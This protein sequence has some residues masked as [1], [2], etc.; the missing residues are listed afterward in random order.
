MHSILRQHTFPIRQFLL[1]TTTIKRNRNINSRTITKIKM[2][3][4]SSNSAPKKLIT[5]NNDDNVCD[6]LIIGG[7]ASGWSFTDTL[8]GTSKQPLR[9]IM[10]D[11]HS[12]PGG[13][14]NDSYEFVRLHQP[15]S[16][17]G[18]ESKK[19]EVEN[20]SDHRATRIEL[21]QYYADVQ[22]ELETKHDFEFVGDTTLDLA[23]LT[24]NAG[25]DNGNN[26]YI[27]KNNTTG[28]SRTINVRKRIVDARNL[29][30]DLPISTPPKFKFPADTIAVAPVND[31]VTSDNILKQKHFVVV[32][33]GKTGM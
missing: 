33:G 6:Y 24:E 26:N 1:T 15:S 32:G 10:V 29:E 13:Q 17:Y 28:E 2:T 9:V 12:A 20:S 18:I 19:L 30:P 5:N 23:Q 27:I 21:L 11:Q 8:L 4:E 14:W 25:K 7:G 22:K 31:I 16:M 3:N